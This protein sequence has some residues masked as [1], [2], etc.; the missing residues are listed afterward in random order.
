MI[1]YRSLRAELLPTALLPRERALEIIFRSD[2]DA[3]VRARRRR[4]GS[5]TGR[6]AQR[7]ARRRER[8]RH[9]DRPPLPPREIVLAWLRSRAASPALQAFVQAALAVG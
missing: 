5:R 6:P 4:R 8:S 1:T 7:R 2:D 9:P 3:T